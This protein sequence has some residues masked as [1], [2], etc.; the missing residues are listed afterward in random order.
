MSVDKCCFSESDGGV[1]HP[2]GDWLMNIC[3]WT[4]ELG[5]DHT[6]TSTDYQ[7]DISGDSV[8]NEYKTVYSGTFATS[9]DGKTFAFHATTKLS[10]NR[11]E[12]KTTTV[13]ERAEATL[14]FKPGGVL[15][16]H[17][18]RFVGQVMTGTVPSWLKEE[19]PTIPW[20]I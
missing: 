5:K 7:Y 16:I 13:N 10:V 11:D 14:E 4:L 20:P 18:P 8:I 9:A 12:K 3:S 1:R 2:D 19:Y 6:F 15:A 17:V